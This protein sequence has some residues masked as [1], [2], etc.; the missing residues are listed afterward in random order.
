MHHDED[1]VGI[2]FE[3]CMKVVCSIQMHAHAPNSTC[4]S[5]IGLARDDFSVLT[6]GKL[7]ADN[8]QRDGRTQSAD[9]KEGLNRYDKT[10]ILCTNM[11]KLLRLTYCLSAPAVIVNLNCQQHTLAQLLHVQRPVQS[12]SPDCIISW[13]LWQLPCNHVKAAAAGITTPWCTLT[14]C[15]A[16]LDDTALY[17][18][19]ILAGV[20]PRLQCGVRQ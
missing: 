9:N 8:G 5:L 1:E 2:Q 19:C 12:G 6:P 11:L 10:Q 18:G 20:R 7:P 3:S 16:Q 15:N 4:T 14:H 17:V 13:V